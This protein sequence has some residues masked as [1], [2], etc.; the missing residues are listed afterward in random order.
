MAHLARFTVLGAN[1]FLGGAL[2]ARLAADGHQVFRPTRSELQSLG[3]R[4]LGHVFYSLATKDARIDP[5]GAFETHVAHLAQILRVSF[6]SSLTYIS[7]TRVYLGAQSSDEASELKILPHDDNAI[8]NVMK[9]AGEQLCFADE[10]PVVRV[11]RLSNLIGFAPDGISLIP[12]LIKDALKKGKMRLTISPQSSKDYVAI[13]DA[14]DL[15]PRIALEGRLRCYNLAS[16]RNV[17]LGEIVRIIQSEIPSVGEW[18]S[19]APTIVFP[20]IDTNRIRE[21]FA[22]VARPLRGAL[23]SVVSE[24]RQHVTM[25]RT[26]VP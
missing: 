13:E 8:F 12:I 14:L 20:T 21:E 15:L 7:S 18:R 6:F 2:A 24:Y 5:Y 9:L 11:V 1:G 19:H 17:S 16:S 22:F 26:L 3:D 23:I 25:Q 4:D 10:R